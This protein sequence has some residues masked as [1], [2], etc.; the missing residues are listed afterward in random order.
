LWIAFT[1]TEG[2]IYLKSDFPDL[3]YVKKAT[4]VTE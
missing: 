2:N 3:D 1:G 4:I